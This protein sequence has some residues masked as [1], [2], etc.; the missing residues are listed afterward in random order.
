MYLGSSLPYAM[1][2][3]GNRLNVLSHLLHLHTTASTLPLQLMPT[4]ASELLL[5]SNV[6][7]AAQ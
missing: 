4:S 3:I 6:A 7:R 1:D 2:A 5:Q